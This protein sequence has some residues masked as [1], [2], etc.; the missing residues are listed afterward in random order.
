MLDQYYG[1]C[2]KCREECGFQHYLQIVGSSRSWPHFVVVFFFGRSWGKNLPYVSLNLFYHCQWMNNVYI[3]YQLTIE[4]FLTP[5]WLISP[6]VSVPPKISIFHSKFNPCHRRSV[7]HAKPNANIFYFLKFPSKDL[8]FYL[9]NTKSCP[10][11]PRKILISLLADL[12]TVRAISYVFIFE[13]A[14]QKKSFFVMR[15]S[16]I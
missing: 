5:W 7:Y 12:N 9:A 4:I 3:L 15:M 2:G 6:T 1:S 10:Q 14:L 11:W 8:I 13:P 16:N